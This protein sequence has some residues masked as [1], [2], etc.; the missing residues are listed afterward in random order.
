MEI[1]SFQKIHEIPLLIPENIKKLD[2]LDLFKFN[3][4]IEKSDLKMF[5][6]K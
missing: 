4:N 6:G 2:I 3:F 1:Y 5:C